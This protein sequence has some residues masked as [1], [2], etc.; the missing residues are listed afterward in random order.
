MIL[1]IHPYTP[2]KQYN[3]KCKRFDIHGTYNY[4]T[5]N[6]RAV[7]DELLICGHSRGAVT[8]ILLA[9]KL[10]KDK[11]VDPYRISLVCSEPVP[12]NLSRSARLLFGRSYSSYSCTVYT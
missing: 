6:H 4:W 10:C 12:G 8:A 3:D 7:Y 2:D 1:T 5:I 9:I 11:V